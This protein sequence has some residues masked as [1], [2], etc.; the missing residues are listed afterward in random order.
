MPLLVRSNLRQLIIVLA[1]LSALI[2][3]FNMFLVSSQ[4]QKDALIQNTLEGNEAYAA[5]LAASA[6]IFLNMAKSELKYSADQ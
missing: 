1:F 2:S 6:S 4:V 5:K 3:V